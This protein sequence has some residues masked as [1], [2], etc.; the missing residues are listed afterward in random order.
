MQYD[1]IDKANSPSNNG[2]FE[3]S[4]GGTEAMY[5]GL[6]SRLPQEIKDK[7]QIICSRVRD[8]D[9]NK[10]QILWLHDRWDDPENNH[11][12]QANDIDRFDKMIFVSNYQFET[13]HQ[14]YGIPYNKSY[15][16][17]NAIE[18]FDPVEKTKEGQV[19]IIYHTTPHRGLEIV[20]PVFDFL[21]KKNPNLHLD[22]YSSFEIYGW[23]ERDEP[24]KALFDF[25]NNHPQITYHGFQPNSVVRDALKKAHIFAFPSIWPETS[26][27]AAI[28][29]AA[30]GCAVIAPDYAALPE[31][32]LN[33]AFMYRFNE[34]IQ[35]H[36]NMF[37]SVLNAMIGKLNTDQIQEHL[38]KQAILFN[39]Y[40]SWDNRILQWNEVFKN[41]P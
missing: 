20:V 2:T 8:I 35:Q 11:F 39:N 32:L 27:I 14:A 19:N 6:I 5:N 26:C 23:K 7:Y 37:T 1:L 4:Q 17:K 13:Y 15:V 30:A 33:Y 24:Y 29:A 10:K 22:V 21:A 25:C 34:D 41:L 40:Y 18:P 31:T 3:K 16:L 38:K 12:R 28:E 36:A 9:P